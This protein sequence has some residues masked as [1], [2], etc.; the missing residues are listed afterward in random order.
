MQ[1]LV[2][3][4]FFFQ[5]IEKPSLNV[6]NYPENPVKFIQAPGCQFRQNS[7]INIVIY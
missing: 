1:K 5:S 2:F 7:L 3:K 4:Q 6:L